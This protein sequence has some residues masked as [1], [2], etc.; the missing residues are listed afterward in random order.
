MTWLMKENLSKTLVIL[1]LLLLP[2]LVSAESSDLNVHIKNGNKYFQKADYGKAIEE[3]K[4][5]LKIS[6]NNAKGHFSLG[7]A[8]FYHYMNEVRENQNKEMLSLFMSPE[9]KTEEVIDGESDQ[10]KTLDDLA[11]DEWKRAIELDDSIRGAHYFLGTYYHN[12]EKYEEAEKELKR[13]IELNPQYSNSYSVLASVYEKMNKIDLAI[14]YHKKTLELDP[15]SESN[16]Y[17]LMRIYQRIGRKK[18][19][20]REYDF[21]KAKKSVFLNGVDPKLFNQGK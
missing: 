5:A 19:A 6:P 20:Q 21:L 18:E 1:F 2:S 13:E 15:D 9:T 17:D 12:V 4:K 3:F 11:V 14:A 16:H 8:Y 7:L 10:T